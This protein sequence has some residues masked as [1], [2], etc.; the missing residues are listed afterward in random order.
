MDDILLH[1]LTKQAIESALESQ[2]LQALLLVG[3]SGAGKGILARRLAEKFLGKTGL[4]HE[5]YYLEIQAASHSINIEQI[6]ELQQFL[7]LKTTGKGRIRR[8]VVIQDAD[9]MTREAQNAA[10]KT[11]EEPPADTALIL[12]A[13]Q[14]EQMLPTIRSRVQAV[15]IQPPSET[16]VIAHF[17]NSGFASAD[18][19]R[20]YAITGGNIGIMQAV[21]AKDVDN[22]LAAQIETA[23]QILTKSPYERLLMVDELSKQKDEL[24]GL[25]IALR[26]ICRGALRQSAARNQA[27]ATQAWYRRL[28]RIS[29]A[30]EDLARS[31]NAKLL[32]TDLLLGL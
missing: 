8:V 31:A 5:A 11:L 28:G 4:Q 23:K 9:K 14:L 7:T 20:A 10:L 26:R 12:T 25:L 16:E 6:R 1:P 17:E 3:P 15:Y 13:S 32:L 30:E 22:L 21:L 18:I 29:Q 19:V 24:D 2:R 27:S